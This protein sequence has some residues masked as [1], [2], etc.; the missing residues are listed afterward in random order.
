MRLAI[1]AL[2]AMAV[3]GT[4]APMTSAFAQDNAAQETAH[5]QAMLARLPADAA[6]RVFG[7]ETTP[8]PGPARPIG[9]YTKGC[10]AGAVQLPADGPTWQVMRPSRNRAWGLPLLIG[11]LEQVAASLPA[12]GWPG[13]L[14]GDMGQPR[15]GPMLTG[16]ASHQIGLDVD[17]WFTPMPA[18]RLSPSE[19]DNISATDLVNGDGSAVDPR[20][21]GPQY[22]R[23]LEVFARRPE[24]ERIFVNPAIKRAL[25]REAG[26]DRAW[27]E[28][29]RP[30]WGHNYHFHVRLAC[31]QGDAECRDQRPPPPGDG[32][33]ADLDWWFTRDTKNLV[34]HAP[35]IGPRLSEMPGACPAIA[36]MP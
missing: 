5:R 31:P 33:G 24:V 10:V 26:A 12:A 4:A 19:R 13:L 17:I 7:L 28:R 18:R 14:V 20:A 6:K 8:A 2:L 9:D 36:R 21:W 11:F 34:P 3:F 15:G 30:W 1:V 35:A 25:C 27:L 32:C 16:H 29:I 23:L 22:G